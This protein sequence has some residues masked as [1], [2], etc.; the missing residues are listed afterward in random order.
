M[1]DNITR[2]FTL[3]QKKRITQY[4]SHP[5]FAIFSILSTHC[6]QSQQHDGS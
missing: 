2:F 5:L 1:S 3:N 6:S 4:L